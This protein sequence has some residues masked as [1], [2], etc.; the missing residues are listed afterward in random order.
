LTVPGDLETKDG[1]KCKETLGSL[2]PSE[3]VERWKVDAIDDAIV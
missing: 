2:F 3:V 1:P